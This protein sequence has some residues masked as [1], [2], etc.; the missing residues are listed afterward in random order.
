MTFTIKFIPILSGI[1][2]IHVYTQNKLSRSTESDS[3]LISKGYKEVDILLGSDMR[4]N[5]SIEFKYA[6]PKKLKEIEKFFIEFFVLKTN[7]SNNFFYT[8]DKRPLKYFD[9]ELVEITNDI[10]TKEK[11]RKE[12]VKLKNIILKINE[13]IMFNRTKATQQYNS[14]FPDWP[15]DSQPA[16]NFAFNKK[17]INTNNSANI[18]NIFIIPNDYRLINLNYSI[19]QSP[20]QQPQ[21]I[22]LNINFSNQERQLNGNKAFTSN[23][24]IKHY[25][26]QKSTDKDMKDLNL[27]EYSPKKTKSN[28]NRFNQNA[29]PTTNMN[30]SISFSK[31]EDNGGGMLNFDLAQ[32]DDTLYLSNN[33]SVIKANFRNIDDSVSQVNV[34]ELQRESKISNINTNSHVSPSS[35]NIIS[36]NFNKK[37]VSPNNN[38]NTNNYN[39]YNSNNKNVNT[40]I[41]SLKKNLDDT[42]IESKNQNN[43]SNFIDENMANLMSLGEKSRD[44]I[45]KLD[46][47]RKISKNNS[48]NRNNINNINNQLV[49]LDEYFNSNNEDN[50]NNI[51]PISNF[52]NNNNI[53]DNAGINDLNTS[54]NFD[55][56]LSTERNVLVRNLD[57][58][59]QQG[60]QDYNT[61]NNM[62]IQASKNNANQANQG[63]QFNIQNRA[64]EIQIINSNIVNNDLSNNNV[65]ND[66]SSRQNTAIKKNSNK[67]F[68]KRVVND[69]Q[70]ENVV[71]NVQVE[72]IKKQ[73]SIFSEK[74]ETD[75]KQKLSF[76][77]LDKEEL[78]NRDN[79]SN[80]NM[81]IRDADLTN[82][83]GTDKSNFKVP[84]K[85]KKVKKDSV[86]RNNI[87][88]MDK[89]Q[90]ENMKNQN[91]NK[92]DDHHKNDDIENNDVV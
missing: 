39:N 49:Q 52:N 46:K 73:L 27:E 84:P 72:L 38:K 83:E 51:V 75:F 53:N 19:N 58:I 60:T 42:Y 16:P 48:E 80:L 63:N 78:E 71:T 6:E 55:N 54:E 15:S 77:K 31:L 2:I 22:N 47:L 40:K 57:D 1:S 69:L 87:F 88:L 14:E 70:I 23:N 5:T 74:N 86:V 36:N 7:I 44:R 82:K 76:L 21:N 13:A 32:K 43:I 62:Y 33:I 61:I 90:L 66:K 92:E 65:N 11:N 4:N 9:Y 25:Y 59:D 79:K 26:S 29:I 10:L 50:V 3:Q 45:D 64:S 24:N 35:K 67:N 81:E 41:P 37:N 85:Q 89:D 28:I 68:D 34:F 30:N 12:G 91:K 20:L 56:R 8:L 18:S 17:K